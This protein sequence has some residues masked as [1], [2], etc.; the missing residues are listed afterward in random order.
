MY[1]DVQSAACEQIAKRYEVMYITL[2]MATALDGRYCGMHTLP[3]KESDHLHNWR[4]WRLG[5]KGKMYLY[6]SSKIYIYMKIAGCQYCM[7]MYSA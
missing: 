2:V 4:K 1:T 6:K 5:T 3:L 7:H